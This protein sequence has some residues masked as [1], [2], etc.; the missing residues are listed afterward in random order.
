MTLST[1][2]SEIRMTTARAPM[3]NNFRKREAV[4]RMGSN[5]VLGIPIYGKQGED[6]GG[7]GKKFC[8]EPKGST[9]H[10]SP[11]GITVYECLKFRTT[12]P[13]AATPTITSI[14]NS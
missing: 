13:P 4:L 9:G 11:K 1:R 7:V 8:H 12:K 14:D 3:M 6:Q 10:K 2:N 5:L